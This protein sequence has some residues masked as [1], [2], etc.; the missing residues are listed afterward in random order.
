MSNKT[1][2]QLKI[3]VNKLQRSLAESVNKVLGLLLQLDVLE[4]CKHQLKELAASRL[5]LESIKQALTAVSEELNSLWC[6]DTPCSLSAASELASET[7]HLRMR[8]CKPN[9]LMFKI[10]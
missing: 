1:K 10:L 5:L 2:G 8:S 3:H 4:D 7:R 6:K 9:C